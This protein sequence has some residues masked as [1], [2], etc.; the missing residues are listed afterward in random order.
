MSAAG[1][2]SIGLR[3]R[4]RGGRDKPGHDNGGKS[5]LREEKTYYV[6][7]LSS[8]PGGALYV[9]VTSDISRR[10]WEHKTRTATSHT[11]RYFIDKLVYYE[12]YQDVRTAIQRESN[13]KH[14][15]RKWKT[16]LIYEFNPTWRD[17][18]DDFAK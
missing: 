2:D 13:I 9:G 4:Y 7:F 8:R 1:R 15:P 12:S 16:N 10:V 11:S 5:H 6:Y 18:Y 3:E 17:L 14:W